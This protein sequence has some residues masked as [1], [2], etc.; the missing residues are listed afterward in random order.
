[1][2][3]LLKRYGLLALLLIQFAPLGPPY[4]N[5]LEEEWTDSR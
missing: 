3:A 1:M 4:V 5:E 2:T